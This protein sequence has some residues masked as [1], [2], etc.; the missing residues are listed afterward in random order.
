MKLE[1][2]S[3]IFGISLIVLAGLSVACTSGSN[4]GAFVGVVGN[5]NPIPAYT[6]IQH[7][8]GG[9]L[10]YVSDG[11][12]TQLGSAAITA[13]GTACSHAVLSLVA[14]GDSSIYTAMQN[15]NIKKVGS[16]EQDHSMIISGIYNRRCTIVR[17]EK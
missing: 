2:L 12:A 10:F 4:I 1:R 8:R 9:G 16:V 13:E 17:G 5:T 7:P 11:E 6:N 15:G 3:G 14:F